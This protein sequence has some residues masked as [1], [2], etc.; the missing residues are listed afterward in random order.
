MCP[1]QGSQPKM[2]KK[3]ENRGGQKLATGGLCRESGGEAP[4]AGGKGV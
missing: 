4:A 3:P 1:K 2:V